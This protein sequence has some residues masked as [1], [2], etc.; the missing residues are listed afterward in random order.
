MFRTFV[1][2]ALLTACA[3]GDKGPVLEGSWCDQEAVCASYHGSTIDVT[4]CEEG[5]ATDAAEAEALGCLEAYEA[6]TDCAV[7]DATCVE[8]VLDHAEVC[9]DA[10]ATYI[11]CV[12]PPD[13]L[14]GR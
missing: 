11:D 8:G 10:L 7:T 3:P 14:G 12:Y 5:Q 6:Y 13:T 2:A 1:I 9:E 4:Q